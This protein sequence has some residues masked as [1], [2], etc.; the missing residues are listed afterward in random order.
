M[1]APFRTVTWSGF[2]PTLGAAAANIVVT[3][4]ALFSGESNFDPKVSQLLRKRQFRGFRRLLRTLV[5][6]AAGSSAAENTTRVKAFVAGDQTTVGQLGG[7]VTMETVSLV[8][9]ST[10]SGPAAT[11]NTTAADVTY[12]TALIDRLSALAP[13]SYPADL[14]G[15]AGGGKLGF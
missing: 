5:G 8:P 6:A 14:S 4:G 15:N 11:R 7:L 2:S 3:N 13:A 10:V 1:T 12:F 9:P